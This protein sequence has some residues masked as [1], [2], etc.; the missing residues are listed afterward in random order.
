MRLTRDTLI[1]IARDTAN[2]RARVSRRII[3][4]YLTG[5]VLHES[6]LLGGTT[7]IDL[8]IIQDSEP[9][10]P[11]EVIRL[12]DEISLDISY[13]AQEVFHTPRRL[14]TDP[15]LGPYIYSKPMVFHDTQHWFDFTQAS[16]GAQFF[17]PDYILQRASKLAQTARQAWMDLEINTSQAHA[18]RVTRYLEAVENAGNAL[19]ALTGEGAPLAE[20]RFLLQLPQRLQEFNQ[21]ELIAGLIHLLIADP[22]RLESAWT[23]WLPG[24]KAA[25]HAASSQPNT[26][27]RLAPCRQM[28]YERGA[29]ALW[30]ENPDAAIW[31]LLRTW[32]RA[33]EILPEE[34]PERPAWQAACQVLGLDVDQFPVRLQELDGYLDRVEE[35]LD[36]WGNENGVSTAEE[37]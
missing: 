33:V 1:K 9:V 28:Y 15:W 31:L 3:C 35:T 8:V 20:R 16:T 18:S 11:R 36:Q 32:T 6:P 12:T 29:A 21:P 26:P 24:W 5:S 23:D 17:Q 2:Q 27:P 34:S 19:V 4:I 10:E 13:Y 22:S 7:D 25:Y 37:T 30:E 14:R